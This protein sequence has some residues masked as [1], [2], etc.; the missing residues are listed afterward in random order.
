MLVNNTEER[1]RMD[2]D[3][4]GLQRVYPDALRVRYVVDDGTIKRVVQHLSPRETRV[5][6]LGKPSDR[7]RSTSQ[8]SAQ[9]ASLC[10]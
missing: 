3:S 9:P 10:R 1:N 4:A 5:V 6:A 7:D 8:G 2:M